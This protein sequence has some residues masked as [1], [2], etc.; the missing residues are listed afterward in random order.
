MSLESFYKRSFDIV[1]V[2]LAGV[3]CSPVLLLVALLL[4]LFQGRILFRQQRPGLRGNPFT[5]YKFCSMT[6]ECDA[7]GVLLDDSQRLTRVGA[8]VRNL[9]L[10]ELPQLWNV[11]K[12]E[13]SL[14]GPRPLLMEYLDRYTPEQARRHEVLPGITGWSQ[15]NGRNDLEWEQK[16][17]LDVWYVD[18]H[19]LALDMRI[20]RTTALKVLRRDGISRN[21][22]ATTPKFMG[23]NSDV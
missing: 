3:I 17:A 18:H 6:E 1:V 16:L 5:L 10:D 4:L 23:S 9:S 7:R 14:V 22:H 8:M 21:G 19:S 2:T 20:L 15:I 12:G 13:M 11:L